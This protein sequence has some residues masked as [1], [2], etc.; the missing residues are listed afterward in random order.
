MN[1]R[2]LGVIVVLFVLAGCGAAEA[3]PVPPRTGTDPIVVIRLYPGLAPAASRFALPSFALLAD[4]TAILAADDRGIVVSG[5]RRTLSA[6]QVTDLYDKAAG[7]GLFESRRY[8]RDVLDGSRLVVQI[9]SAKGRHETSV[10]N[11]SGDEG[12]DRG[13]VV[14]FAAAATRAGVAAGDFKPD[15]VALVIVA[16]SEATTDLRPWPTATPATKMPGYPQRPCLIIDGSGVLGVQSAT[17]DTRWRTDDG[18]T[19][20]LRVRPL[21]PY[22]HSCADIGQ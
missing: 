7:A 2:I 10:D 16:D 20:A 4:G 6:G 3:E 14:D 19:V 15:R 8:R 9:T 12:G 18:H 13:R 17:P 11:P 5:T 22:E 1:L 21:L